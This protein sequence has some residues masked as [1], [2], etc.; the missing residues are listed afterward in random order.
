[1]AG[2]ELGADHTE[3]LLGL[4]YGDVRLTLRGL[5]SVIKLPEELDNRHDLIFHHASLPDF[6]ED[7]IRSGP[8]YVGDE[9]RTDLGRRI[10][11]AF[12]YRSDEP[13]M[14]RRSHGSW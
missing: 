6:L 2:F 3:Q 12:S 11:K 9:H 1:V 13:S 8:F 5:H 7:P 10:L 4:K 14:T